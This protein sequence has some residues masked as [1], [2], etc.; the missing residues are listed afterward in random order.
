MNQK[1][2]G[3]V[4]VSGFLLLFCGVLAVWLA[5]TT[6]AVPVSYY[7]SDSI[8]KDNDPAYNGQ[9]PITPFKTIQRAANLTNPGD[10]VYIMNGT[11]RPTVSV[12]KQQILGISRSGTSDAYITYKQYEDHKPVLRVMA[13]DLTWHHIVIYGASYIKIEG[14]ELYGDV[15]N[16]SY[17]LANGKREGYKVQK[18]NS[19]NPN[20]TSNC[21]ILWDDYGVT[22]TS[23]IT[24]KLGTNNAIPHHIELRNN[25]IHHMPGGG[26]AMLTGEYYTIE[27]NE[28]YNTSSRSFFATSG[29]SLLKLT[30]WNSNTDITSY[31]NIVRNNTVYGNRSEIGWA[32][33]EVEMGYT[34]PFLSDGN[35]IIIDSNKYMI[36]ENTTYT[37]RGKTLV[38]GNISYNNGGSGMHSFK[39]DYVDFIN[40]TASN[41][42]LVVGYPELEANGA[43]NVNFYNNIAVP[44]SLSTPNKALSVINSTSITFDYNILNGAVT[45]TPPTS[46]HNMNTDPKFVNRLAFDFRLQPNSPAIDI[47]ANAFAQPTDNQLNT[48]PQGKNVDRGA[49]EFIPAQQALSRTGAT[50][51]SSPGTAGSAIDGS[52]STSWNSGKVMAVGDQFQLNLGSTKS[53]SRVRFDSTS[54]LYPRDF[55]V[56]VSYSATSLGTAVKSVRGNASTLLDISFPQVAGQYVTL[57]IAIAASANWSIVEMNA[58][59]DLLSRSGWTPVAFATRNTLIPGYAIDGNAASY[60]SS[61]T[62]M[63]AGQIFRIDLGSAKPIGR[64]SFGND[65][66]ANFPA[67]VDVYVHDNAQEP[68]FPVKSLYNNT[69]AMIDLSFHTTTGRYVTLRINTAKANW[70]TINELNFYNK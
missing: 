58:Y 18:K 12:S 62:N 37:Y 53:V 23:G 43:A 42:G 45:G 16:I 44:N 32:D 63:A 40:N 22:N 20:C 4:I 10:T 28:V 17:N 31:K 9:S 64:V 30:N 6:Y 52:S 46:N 26:I 66:T 19:L 68:G 67:G 57:K 56:Y 39:S 14:L 65:G 11:Y 13:S 25:I 29:I 54:G 61:G 49:L 5:P 47:G 34:T 59:T 24:S 8:G 33:K 55:D 35:G 70:W 41:N 36:N 60:W 1:W 3:K 15:A 21:D 7:V 2:F 48:R 50:A 51:N 38:S 69:S 27:N